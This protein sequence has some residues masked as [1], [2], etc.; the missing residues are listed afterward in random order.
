MTPC[1]ICGREPKWHFAFGSWILSCVGQRHA[2][3]MD[4]EGNHHVSLHKAKSQDEILRAWDKAM[5]G[6]GGQ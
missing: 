4:D 2:I 3:I 1:P 5:A 6:K